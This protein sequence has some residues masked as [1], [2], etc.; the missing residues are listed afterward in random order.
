MESNA[1][2]KKKAMIFMED[3]VKMALFFQLLS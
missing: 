1:I 2:A 3:Q